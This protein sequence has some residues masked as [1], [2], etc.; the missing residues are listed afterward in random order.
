MDSTILGHSAGIPLLCLN[1]IKTCTLPCEHYDSDIENEA[2]NSVVVRSCRT[3]RFINL[4][5][6]DSLQR[7]S[8]RYSR[9]YRINY[10][11]SGLAHHRVTYQISMLASLHHLL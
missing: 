2:D 9:L 6:V 11:V 3:D 8:D 5:L 7:I 10:S 1:K 4:L